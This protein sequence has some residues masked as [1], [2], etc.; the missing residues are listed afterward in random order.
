LIET[1]GMVAMEAMWFGKPVVVTD[2]IVS[3]AEIVEHGISGYIVDPSSAEDLT[4]RLTTLATDPA[5]RDRMGG[6]GRQRAQAYRP[7]SVADALEEVYRD[8]LAG[9]TRGT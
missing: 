9:C 1:Q 5:L 6:V 8:V 4:A 3:A 2:Q 7:E